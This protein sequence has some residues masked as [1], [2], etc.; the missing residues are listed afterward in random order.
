MNNKEVFVTKIIGT[1][2]CV[3]S[4]A[5]KIVRKEIVE[6]LNKSDSVNVSF[7]GSEM[8][9]TA[10]LNT[11]IGSLYKDFSEEEIKNKITIVSMTNED[12]ASLKR[13]VDTAKIFYNDPDRIRRSLHA[14][15]G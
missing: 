5:G 14:V 3:D 7:E 6:G 1:N 8:I 11:A 15:M 13:V 4:E 9:T 12:K 10:F 2:F